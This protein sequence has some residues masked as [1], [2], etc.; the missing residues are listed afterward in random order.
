MH[1]EVAGNHH[2]LEN[3]V[4]TAARDVCA[5]NLKF[6]LVAFDPVVDAA[7]AVVIGLLGCAV[8]GPCRR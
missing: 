6:V 7:V 5:P 1:C 4:R 2:P 8:V 3:V